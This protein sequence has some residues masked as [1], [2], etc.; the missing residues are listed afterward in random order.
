MLLMKLLTEAANETIGYRK[1]TKTG[2]ISTETWKAIEERRK[3]EDGICA[4]MLNADEEVGPLTL[5]PIL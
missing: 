1:S 4:E 2:C 3:G 5:Q